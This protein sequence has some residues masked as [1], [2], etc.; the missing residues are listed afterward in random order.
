MSPLGERLPKFRVGTGWT[1]VEITSEPY[2]VLTMK[3]YVPA[4]R[5]K[6]LR[7]GLEYEM[8]ISAKSLAEGLEPMR[9]EKEH[10]NGVQF[11]VRKESTEQYAKYMVES[12]M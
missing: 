8:F 6:S 4:V 11:R 3:G 1:E 9:R 5:V 12:L 10:F 7:N 2:V